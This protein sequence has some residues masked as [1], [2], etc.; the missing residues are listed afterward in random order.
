MIDTWFIAALCL[1][2][3]AAGALVRVI[4]IPARYDRIAA[5]TAFVTIA[6]SAGI[7]ISLWQGSILILDAVIILALLCYAAIIA[8]CSATGEAEA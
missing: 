3:I 1:L 7:T 5:A 8:S 4:R 2:L 6:G